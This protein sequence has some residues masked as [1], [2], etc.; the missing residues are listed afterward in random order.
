MLPG[1]A[2]EGRAVVSDDGIHP[3]RLLFSGII[4]GHAMPRNE[5]VVRRRKFTAAPLLRACAS[6]AW[7]ALR[8]N[9][10]PEL[11]EGRLRPITPSKVQWLRQPDV[12]GL[13]TYSPMPQRLSGAGLSSVFLTTR[14]GTLRQSPGSNIRVE[15]LATP[16]AAGVGLGWVNG[17]NVPFLVA[18]PSIQKLTAAS[19]CTLTAQPCRKWRHT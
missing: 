16:G 1:R 17:R 19:A 12:T 3:L 11:L 8:S 4:A 9:L 7:T 10:V 5:W 6:A 15:D 14:L 2:D 18:G 13:L